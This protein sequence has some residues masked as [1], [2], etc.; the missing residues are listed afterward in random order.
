MLD[1]LIPAVYAQGAAVPATTLGPPPSGV[2][3][4][5]ETIQRIINLSV[6]FAFI[7]LAVVLVWGGIQYIMSGGD[8]KQ[9]GKAQSTFTWALLGI[10]FLG[11]AW[12]ILLLVQA[13]TGVEITKVCIGF[14]GA[15]TKCP[16]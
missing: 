5:Q 16:P 1:K 14:P 7:A 8:P 6:G 15:P 3:Q 10:L 2:L 9:I 4:L 11:I 12:L 13:F